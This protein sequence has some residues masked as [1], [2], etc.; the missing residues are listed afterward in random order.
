MKRAEL[1]TV[2]EVS[3]I[4]RIHPMTVYEQA[5]VGRLPGF[6]LPSGRWRFDRRE[7][8]AWI[9]ETR[10]ASGSSRKAECR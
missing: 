5:R 2:K 10:K 1:L 7:I 6:R 3:E 4:L 8:E 9:R